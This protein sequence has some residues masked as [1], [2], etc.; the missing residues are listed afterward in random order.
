[1]IGKTLGH[2]RIL[3]KI[4]Q[5]GM[6]EVF[7]AE[8]TSLHRKVALKFL[9]PAMQQ[10][11]VARK[12]FI[13]E[14]RTAAALD[15]PYI[16]HINDF[17]ESEGQDFIVMEYVEGQSLKERLLQGPLPLEDALQ[18][19][20][21]V[22]EAL[23]A[24]HGKGIIH[25]DI[26][27][28]N[29]FVTKRGHAKILD[30]GL[31]RMTPVGIDES[32]TAIT[33]LTAGGIIL[34]TLRY[35][36]PEQARGESVAAPS[37]IFSLGIVLYE[38]ATGRH[39]FPAASQI[40]VLHAILSDAPVPP[41]RLRPEIPAALEGLILQMLEKDAR[42]RP[43]AAAVEAA[44]A[45]SPAG[46]VAA[47][48]AVRPR[49]TVGREKESQQLHSAYDSA[50]AGHG[51]MACVAGEAGIGKTTLVD[52]FLADLA[53]R[54]KPCAIGRGRCSERLAGSEAYL[55]ILESLESLLHGEEG[56]TVS[57][58]MKLVAPTWYVQVA[59]L[60]S[61]DS[62]F[63]RAM[64]EAKTAS[65]ERMK[66]ELV[67]LLQEM[68]RARPL[69]LFLDDLHWADVSTVD[70]LAY[71]GTRLES[72]RLLVIG[73]YRPSDLLL[74]KHPFV[75]VKLE[76]QGRG[77]ARE[78]AVEFLTLE[79]LGKYLALEFPEHR[80]PPDL[81]D[82]LHRR[83]EGNALFMAD[84]VRYLKD[85]RV[86][87]L[88][89][90]RWVLAQ[91][92]AEIER[93]LPESVRSMIE[94]KI[95][96]L[97]DSDRRLLAAA[98]VQ[99]HEFDSAV[100]AKALGA[101][102]ADF[103][104]RLEELDRLHGLVYL[105]GDRELPDST[106]TLRYCFVHALYQNALYGS[107]TAT[108]K[109]SLSA[110]VAEALLGFYGDRASEAAS[111][112]ALLFETARNFARASD[113]FL[114]AAGNARRVYANQEALA[115]A[116]RAMGNAEKLKG[117]AR[118]AG[119]AAAA[120]VLADIHQTLTRLE[121]A[122][123][124][125]ASAEEAAREG[126]D[127]QVQI[128]SILGRAGALMIFKRLE[129]ADQ[130]AA[131]AMEMARRAGSD[132]A[133]ASAEAIL[134]GLRMVQGNLV[135]ADRYY[136]RA[137]PV[138]QRSGPPLIAL[139]ACGG[140]CWMHEY[141]L[142]HAELEG[143]LG[144]MRPRVEEIGGCFYLFYHGYIGALGFGNQ[145]RISQALFALREIYR[146]SDLNGDQFWFPR[147]PNALGWLHRE[148]LD[149]EAALKLDGDGAR[150]ALEMGCDEAE[151]NSHVNLG[152]DYLALGEPARAYEHLEEAGR[153]FERDVWNRWRYNIRLQAERAGYWIGRGDLK[154][155]AAYAAASLESA[156]T[157]LSRKHWAWAH[158]L[159]GDIALLEDRAP[160]ARREYEQAL[161]I[162]QRHSCPTIEW[163]IL[164]AAAETA[165]RLHDTSSADSFRARARHVVRSL[166][167]SITE[168][169]LRERFL[170]SKPIRDI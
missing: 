51:L 150:I 124:D 83:T 85:R 105:E 138:L 13:R 131:R 79:D 43:T 119:V 147:V 148:L 17:G 59:P 170:A 10:D 153:I 92:L 53:A 66:R 42:L 49:H 116:H 127:Q 62:S 6:G 139:I 155:A 130:E 64:A 151:A 2:Y 107:L 57:R 100:V 4:G 111:E 125:F 25:R 115:L 128:G 86:I 87:T 140:R 61:E 157:T 97:S 154:Q 77:L 16:C 108:R 129:Q 160:E 33:E 55:P 132:V 23:D 44:L 31:A 19:T 34:G 159:F 11:S 91:S 18:I 120:L 145:G 167:E 126:G 117:A 162:L 24:A 95:S 149:L 54:G 141:R 135:E 35:M 68:S 29:I 76:L 20:I 3:E 48:A 156:K 88:Q 15:H 168:P 36:S 165:R 123:A 101:G 72:M 142:E 109:T 96:R 37:D 164:L 39:P 70:L 121:E 143:L 133:V 8:D 114:I 84:L 112:L 12:R 27:P 5:G 80:L 93:E 78:I 65:Q 69:V 73:A 28:A 56:E 63:A 41:S 134:A 21:E 152:H 90:G 47:P 60:A 67:A 166:A 32:E 104:E 161:S 7:L 40:G 1:M 94:K 136:D 118:S 30:F 137:I 169:P 113:Y 163:R 122:I 45:E 158:K 71:I 102:Q 110:A 14:A 9:P 52:H 89:E 38:L 74:A 82:L 58:I 26:K 75:P 146:L 81:P 50:L 98:S 106:L 22:A 46:T 103:E 144:W 99:G